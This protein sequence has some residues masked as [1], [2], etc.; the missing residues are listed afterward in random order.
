MWRH[1]V[2]YKVTVVLEELPASVIRI[3]QSKSNMEKV[4]QV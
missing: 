3:S 2:W 4:V 1:V